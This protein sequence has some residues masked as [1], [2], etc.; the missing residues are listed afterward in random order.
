MKL[1]RPLWWDAK[2][3]QFKDDAAANALCARK[4]RSAAYDIAAIVK[5]AGL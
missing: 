4:P 5:K 3:E 1:Q 2:A